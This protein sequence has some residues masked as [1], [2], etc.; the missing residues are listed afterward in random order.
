VVGAFLIVKKA[1]VRDYYYYADLEIE[2]KHNAGANLSAKTVY[3][4]SKA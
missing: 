3:G 4:K 1:S 2:M